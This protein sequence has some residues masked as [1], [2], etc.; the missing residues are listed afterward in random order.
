MLSSWTW[1]AAQN[2]YLLF[3]LGSTSVLVY[4]NFLIL[5]DLLSSSD[6]SWPQVL[7]YL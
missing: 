5:I 7:I 1:F 6:I 2:V 3:Y 4:D